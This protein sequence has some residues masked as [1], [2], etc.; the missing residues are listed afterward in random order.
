MARLQQVLFQS[1]GMDVPEIQ[2]F[3]PIYQ[4]LNQMVKMDYTTRAKNNKYIKNS[5]KQIINVKLLEYKYFTC[6]SFTPYAIWR[7]GLDFRHFFISLL[8]CI[9]HPTDNAIVLVLFS[10]SS[11]NTQEF[12]ATPL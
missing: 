3:L 2:D 12:K 5:Y 1:I 8:F 4:L 7:A 11:I 10:G 9:G 6:K